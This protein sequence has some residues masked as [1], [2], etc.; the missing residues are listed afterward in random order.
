MCNMSIAQSQWVRFGLAGIGRI[1]ADSQ[2]CGDIHGQFFD[3]M[4]LFKI[5]GDCPDTSYIFM[6][7]LAS[8]ILCR[9]ETGNAQ[10]D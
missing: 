7:T 4:E 2:I 5:G 6:G 9:A 1:L 10:A 8:R 3:L